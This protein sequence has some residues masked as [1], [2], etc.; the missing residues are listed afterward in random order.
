MRGLTFALV[1][2]AGCRIHFDPLATTDAATDAA[3]P[4]RGILVPG[5]SYFRSYDTAADGLFPNMTNPATVSAFRLDATE[6]TVARFRVFVDQG[7]GTQQK[8]PAA[9][10]G[11]HAAIAA[12]GWQTAWNPSLPVDAAA[13][14][15]VSLCNTFQTWTDAP[16]ANENKP[17]NCTSWY[18]AMAFCIWEGG[19][20]PTE[21]EWN[22]AAAGGDEQRAF[23]WSMPVDDT[24]IDCTRADYMGCGPGPSD[25]GATPGG[26]GRWG[27]ADLGGNVWEW[28]IDTDSGYPLP[29]DD[30]AQLSA[31]S[32]RMVRGGS[33][34]STIPNLRVGDRFQYAI[35][36]HTDNVGF[37][38][39]YAP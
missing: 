12:S 25:V 37:R 18:V 29:C 6:V 24:T 14:K 9:D 23:P 36:A 19:Y 13:L 26:T 7:Y 39:A 1:A 8:P 2:L 16:G 3:A 33:F 27:H 34:T 5:G 4:P 38:C 17:M 10:A 35:T 11:A 21:A 32:P 22:F 28:T 31:I 20:L 15:A 30:C